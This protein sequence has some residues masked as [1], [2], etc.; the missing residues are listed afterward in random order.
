MIGS[1]GTLGF[2]SSLTYNTVIEHK[3][4]A[5]SLVFF[6]DIQTTCR[7]VSALA[8]A[9]VSAVELMDRTSLSFG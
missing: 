7:A 6:P 8:N 1:E 9:N 2:I 3:H 5:S 4:R